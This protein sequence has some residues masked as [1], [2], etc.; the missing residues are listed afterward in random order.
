MTQIIISIIFVSIGLAMDS[1]AVS[2]CK[3]LTMPIVQ[4]KKA[5]LIGLYF[6]GFQAGMPVIGYLLGTSFRSAIEHVDHWIALI[7]LV[8]IGGNMI[9]EAFGPEEE[10]NDATDHRTLFLL[11]IATSIDALAVGITLPIMQ[12]PFWPTILSIGVITF[13]LSFFG[14]SLGHRL[15]KRYHTGA[16]IIGGFILILLGI[17]T[18]IEHLSQ[19]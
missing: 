17:K 12:L 15:G 8:A 6:G 3:G 9:R 4:P 7:L 13:T 2:I 11:A 19:S 5:V 1:F 10:I 14:V 18:V 16:Q